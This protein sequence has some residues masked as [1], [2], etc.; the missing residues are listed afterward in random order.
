MTLELLPDTN[1]YRMKAPATLTVKLI[2]Q[3]QPVSG[4]LIMALNRQ[5]PDDV[6]RVESGPGGRAEFRVQR[7]G[8]WMVKAVHMVR[9]AAADR[10]DWRSYWASLTFE[11]PAGP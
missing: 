2:Y 9:A 4:A 1:P 6:Q 5:A 10:E 8:V 7:G 3:G 11:V